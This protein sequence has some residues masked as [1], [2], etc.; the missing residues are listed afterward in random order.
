MK[1]HYQTPMVEIQTIQPQTKILFA[2]GFAPEP[3]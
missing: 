3:V 2:S 1:E